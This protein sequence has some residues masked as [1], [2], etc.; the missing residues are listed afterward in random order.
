MRSPFANLRQESGRRISTTPPSGKSCAP[1]L[2]LLG[3]LGLL[4]P[5]ASP[6]S[7]QCSGGTATCGQWTSHGSL[8][9]SCTDGSRSRVDR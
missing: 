7:P 2:R 1:P 8:G 6:V 5:L 3:P 4:I 9:I